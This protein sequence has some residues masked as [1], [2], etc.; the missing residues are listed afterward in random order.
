LGTS[1]NADNQEYLFFLRAGKRVFYFSCLE[2][3][4]F[5]MKIKI[6]IL[7]LL[8]VVSG[9]L[10]LF[11][12]QEKNE[13]VINKQID[14]IELPA[15]VKA[16]E[17]VEASSGSRGKNTTPQAPFV[18]RDE[19]VKTTEEKFKAVMIIGGVKLETE[20]KIGDSAYD[21]MEN[22]KSENK[23]NFFGRNYPGLGFFVEEINGVKNNPSGENWIYY[24]NGEPA[25]VGISNYILKNNDIIEWKYEEKF[26]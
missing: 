8:I 17:L 20:I 4:I 21:L 6:I 15:E 3:R 23:I 16:D 25:P 24:V 7:A 13:P 14:A 26:F 9:A 2:S 5:V 18:R 1:Q 12:N 19:N 10:A 22:L 11:L